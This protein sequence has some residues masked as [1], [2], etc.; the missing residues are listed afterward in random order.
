MYSAGQNNYKGDRIDRTAVLGHSA[1]QQMAGEAGAVRNYA[2]FWRC[3][4]SRREYLTTHSSVPFR[5]G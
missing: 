5:K 3:K 2:A 1:S 4:L